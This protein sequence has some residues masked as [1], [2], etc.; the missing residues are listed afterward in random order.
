MKGSI[1]TYLNLFKRNLN[2]TVKAK[3]PTIVIE[4]DDWGNIRMPSKEVF[5]KSIENYPKFKNCH[6]LK[7]DAL[8][9]NQD[10]NI[11]YEFLDN[12]YKKTGKKVV[13]TA[14][15]NVC[16]PDFQKINDSNFDQYYFEKIETTINRYNASEGGFNTWREIIDSDYFKPQYH[17]REHVNTFRWLEDL[18]SNNKETLFAFQNNFYGISN[19]VSHT[20]RK[21]YMEAY[22]VDKAEEQE[23]KIKSFENGLEIFKEIFGYQSKSFIAPNYAWNYDIEKVCL[24]NGVSILQGTNLQKKYKDYFKEEKLIRLSRNVF[25]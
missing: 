15:L 16:N 19:S 2:N 4:S 5:K 22:A 12:F 25:F 14:N 7:Y 3:V 23:F 9:S 6:Y 21:S 11:I 20:K 8:E 10:L 17:G 18:K 13:I 1:L 24:K